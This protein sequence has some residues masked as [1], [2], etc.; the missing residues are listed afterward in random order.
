MAITRGDGDEAVAAYVDAHA[1]EAFLS[2]DGLVGWMRIP[3]ISAD[4][5]HAGDVAAS[6]RW[7]VQA[8]RRAGFPLVETLP[9]AG[10]PAVYAEWPAADPGAPTVLLYGH[11]D[12]QPVDPL[13]LWHSAPFEP[14]VRGEELFGRGAID[15]K[16]QVILHLLGLR[17]HLHATG[18]AAP[19]VSLKVLVEGEEESGSPN[20]APLL[21]QHRE[22]LRCDVVVVSDSSVF[23]RDTPSLCTGMR[24]LVECQVDL[25]GPEVDLHSGSFGGGVPNPA[26]A[27]ARLVA[28]LHDAEGKVTIPGFYDRVVELSARE[29]ELFGK[30]PF[31]S[32]AWVRGPA[33]SRA[34]AGEAGYSTPERIW[35]RPTAEVN[36]IWGGYTG[37]GGKTIIPSEAHAKVS[38]RLVFDQRPDEVAGAFA[39]WVDEHVEPGI[40]A[41]VHQGGPGVR[42]CLTPLDDPALRAATRAM[43]RAFAREILFT[44]EGGSGPEADLALILEAPVIFMG[45]GLPDDRIHAPNE[46]VVLPMLRAGAKAA[47]YLWEELA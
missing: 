10:H 38:F 11:H 36:G 3:S 26:A 2:E 14:E 45:F 27:L 46:R 12:V 9:T 39:G 40:V 17:A 34:A 19:A 16:G 20:F 1:D 13:R 37:P 41:R 42:P 22:K 24:G 18:G 30:L 4:P 29:R 32:D 7:L 31:D 47:A 44:R 35:A 33:R 28:G 8:L 6:A 21:R 5:A 23:D 25:R 43:E 15:D